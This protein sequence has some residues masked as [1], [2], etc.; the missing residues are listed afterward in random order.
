MTLTRAQFDAA[1]K[2]FI[3][4]IDHK[5]LDN[6]SDTVLRRFPTGWSWR[7]H[8][9]YPGL[10]YLSRSVTLPAQC[11]VEESDDVHEI[12]DVAVESMDE[13]ALS[14]S[15]SATPVTCQ[16]YVVY[17]ATFQVP[18][19]YFSVHRSD[20]VGLSLEEIMSTPLF[21][22][23]VFPDTQTSHGVDVPGS[24]FALLSQGDH[25][26]LDVPC[27]YLHPCHTAEVIDEILEEVKVNPSESS[28]RYLEAWF[29]VVGNMINWNQS[30]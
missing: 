18:A 26:T 9:S 14:V 23:H 5:A 19:F 13:A 29:M 7:E 27:W 28:E 22:P 8:N 15:V 6:G 20:G 3:Q 11:P 2:A 16:Q 4:K 17:S 30:A 21:R 12:Q 25:P 10:G 1:C 24:A